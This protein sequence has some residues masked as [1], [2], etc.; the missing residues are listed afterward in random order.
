MYLLYSSSSSRS[1]IVAQTEH[2]TVSKTEGEEDHGN[3]ELR[4]T[5]EPNMSQARPSQAHKLLRTSPDPTFMQPGVG[6]AMQVVPAPSRQVL[7]GGPGRGQTGP[8]ASIGL[9]S[10]D[11]RIGSSMTNSVST[12]L[13]TQNF[14]G[15]PF[16]QPAPVNLHSMAN[17]PF[18]NA[19]PAPGNLRNM[20]G[21]PVSVS[22]NFEMPKRMMESGS[23]GLQMQSFAGFHSAQPAPRN[24][25]NQ[26]QFPTPQARFEVWHSLEVNSSMIRKGSLLGKGSYAEVFEGVYHG[27]HGKV[28]CAVKVYRQIQKAQ[29]EAMEEIKIMG[30]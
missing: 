24:P 12:S 5:N 22:G 15:F 27:M 30:K 14:G 11:L 29:D 9:V 23:T 4:Q 16:A 18:S 19:Q 8:S 6:Q 3:G 26:G 25:I 28:K 13:Q 1:A 21:G 7:L 17:R 10:G 20:T 2:T